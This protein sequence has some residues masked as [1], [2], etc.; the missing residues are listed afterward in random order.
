MER[1]GAI[2]RKITDDSP[3][4]GATRI[5]AKGVIYDGILCGRV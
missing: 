3:F 5:F 2:L 1:F 4:D